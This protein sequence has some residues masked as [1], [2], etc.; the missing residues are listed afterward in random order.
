MNDKQAYE[1]ENRDIKQAA[2]VSRMIELGKFPQ[3]FTAYG[4]CFVENGQQKYFIS[5]QAELVYDFIYAGGQHDYYPSICQEMNR[6]F[7]VPSG[8]QDYFAQQVKLELAKQ[9]SVSYPQRFMAELDQFAKRY[10]NDAA[11]PVL[12]HLQQRLW[13]KF[14]TDELQLF[15]ALVKRAYRRKNLLPRTYEQYIC[16]LDGQLHQLADE[17]VVKDIFEKTLYGVVYYN[18]AGR[19]ISYFNADRAT[20]YR[21][22]EDAEAKHG[23]VSPLFQKTYWYN[24]Q[25]RLY[26]V[27]KDFAEHLNHLLDDTYFTY[28][29]ALLQQSS[30]VPG[31]DYQDFCQKMVRD[32]GPRTAALLERYGLWWGAASIGA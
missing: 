3:E 9:L 21:R 32:H 30:A 14:R 6:F 12:S 23:L 29:K 22:F 16:W 1:F 17:A 26:D 8:C 31:A 13:G 20:M 2:S 27:R 4:C 18:Q 25:Y 11:E 15:G 10:A 28:L 24:Y 19:R 5:A 7:L